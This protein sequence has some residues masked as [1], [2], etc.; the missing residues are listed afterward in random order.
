MPTLA[1][2]GLLFGRLHPLALRARGGL[3]GESASAAE[4]FSCARFGSRVQSFSVGLVETRFGQI[5]VYGEA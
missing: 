1:P 3:D 4:C 2:I 5:A